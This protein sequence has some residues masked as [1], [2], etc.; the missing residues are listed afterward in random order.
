MLKNVISFIISISCVFGWSQHI[1]FESFETS[2]GLSNNSVIDIEN[3][4]DGGLWI[5]T[6]D[7]LNYYDGYE[8]TIYKHDVN[9]N[10]SIPGNYIV[11]LER[12]NAGFIWI[13]TRGGNVSKYIGN[14]KFQNLKF[15]EAPKRMEVSKKGNIIIQTEIFHKIQE[16][17]LKE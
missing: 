6:W 13:F 7:G 16:C 17:L 8:F 10:T 9:D 15:D 4:L 3:D 14:N 5:A 2:S 1:K 11:K 12:D